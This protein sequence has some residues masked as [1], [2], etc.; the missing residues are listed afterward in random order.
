MNWASF[1]LKI[2]KKKYEKYFDN[3]ALL[4][5]ISKSYRLMIWIRIGFIIICKLSISN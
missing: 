2:S 3:S 5:E 1:S 4:K